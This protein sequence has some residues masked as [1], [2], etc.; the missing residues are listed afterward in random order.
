ME[1]IKVNE[2]VSVGTQSIGLKEKETLGMW[3]LKEKATARQAEGTKR[4]PAS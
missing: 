2:L 3:G 4:K 1:V